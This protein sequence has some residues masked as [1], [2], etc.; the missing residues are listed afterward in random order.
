MHAHA[1]AALI[2]AAEIEEIP[3]AGHL[4]VLGH[5]DGVVPFIRQ[6]SPKNQEMI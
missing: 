2:P 3:D 4:A 5:I 6:R 1:M